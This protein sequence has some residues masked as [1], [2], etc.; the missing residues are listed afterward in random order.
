[1]I[2]KNMRAFLIISVC[3][4][5]FS[6]GVSSNRVE[7][8]KN[9][10][11][12]KNDSK[13]TTISSFEI[14]KEYKHDT[15]AFTQGLVFHNGFL[16]EGT[17]GSRTRGDDFSSSLRKIEVES[18]K[19]LQKRDLPNDV[20]GEGIVI[21]GDKIYQLTWKEGIAYEY[22]LDDFKLIKEFRYSGEGWGLTSDG[23]N[24]FQSDGTHVI[25]VVNPENFETVRT[26][27]VF[28][29]DGSPLMELNELEYVKGEIWANIWQTNR[30]VRI[31]PE[32][33][34]LLGWID[35]S[36]LVDDEMRKTPAADVLNGIAYDEKSDRL[37]VTGKLWSRVFEIKLSSIG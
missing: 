10:N 4:M 3:L 30:I 35:L 25:R 16:Y 34:K 2:D 19:V 31:D 20:F 15:A 17:G 36:K 26:I 37:F 22:G 8:N 5:I 1:M 9:T 28:D 13:P 12:A 27:S 21:L 24:L 18:G 33:G 11:L 6:C 32:S 29:E 14:V 23:K 7:E